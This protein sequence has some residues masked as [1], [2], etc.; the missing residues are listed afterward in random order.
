M[1]GP[2]L[3]TLAPLLKEAGA[4]DVVERRGHLH[5]YRSKE[6]FEKEALAWRLRREN[7]VEWDEFNAD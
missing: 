1:V 2:C 3:E 7:G 4:E 6:T 5:V